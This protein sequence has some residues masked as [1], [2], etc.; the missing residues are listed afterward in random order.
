MRRF[1]AES[2]LTVQQI[3]IGQ[4]RSRR[5]EALI[6]YD[7]LRA[8]VVKYQAA[9][10][11]GKALALPIAEG[12]FLQLLQF[13][14]VD[15]AEMF[16]FE[17]TPSR[18]F[19][20]IKRLLALT[21]N[22]YGRQVFQNAE[23][24]R[25][26]AALNELIHRRFAL[27]AAAGVS[28][29][30]EYNATVA[31]PEKWH[32][33][34]MVGD[35]SFGGSFAHDDGPL[36]LL[37]T[38]N[39]QG[40]AAGIVVMFVHEFNA[41]TLARL[42]ETRRAALNEFWKETTAHAFGFKAGKSLLP[43]NQPA[44]LWRVFASLGFTAS[45]P[46]AQRVQ[47]TDALVERAAQSDAKNPNTNFLDIP[48]G[49]AGA[50]RAHFTLGEL[51]QCF[52]AMVAGT[53]RTGKTRMIHNVLVSACE[54]AAPDQLQ[55][56]LFDFKSGAEFGR[57]RGLAHL[58][59]YGD[60]DPSEDPGAK[61]LLASLEYVEQECAR[62]TTIFKVVG[63]STVAAYNAKAATPLPRMLVVVDE[64]HQM[65]E[66]KTVAALRTA[67][68]RM[69]KTVSTQGAA[70]GVHLLMST[71]SFTFEVPDSVVKLQAQLRIG[72]K[73]ASDGAISQL[74]SGRHNP[75]LLTLATR[76]AIINANFGELA[77]NQTV[78]LDTFTDEDFDSRLQALKRRCP[79]LL[80]PR[81][82]TDSNKNPSDAEAQRARSKFADGDVTKDWG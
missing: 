49:W 75:A 50:V 24:V 3:N 53:T 40:P 81:E 67:F 41:A 6:P 4:L 2:I 44:E 5:A 43:I 70:Y 18:D 63:T 32:Y 26:L 79:G 57:Y 56:A 38:L 10:D 77:D 20:Q 13:H 35:G 54:N 31:R 64:M 8:L 46:D 65:Y 73:L 61:N 42:P 12:V 55:I 71:Q 72:F 60:N 30:I 58:Q 74:M 33:L 19:A 14:A 22:R 39:R 11:V 69:L 27:F 45:C 9:D 17:A 52:H 28:N 29:L 21:K 7:R 15:A 25:H 62:R 37:A 82:L 51:S 36:S 34:L 78:A 23:F 47:L 59:A 80:A 76:T 66:A 68:A 1:R 48:I 16:F